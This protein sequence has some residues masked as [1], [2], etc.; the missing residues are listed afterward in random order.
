M[1]TLYVE[2]RCNPNHP[3]F[4]EDLETLQA[5]AHI[6]IYE[7]YRNEISVSP[8]FIISFSK[9]F[10]PST[11]EASD[12]VSQADDFLQCLSGFTSFN[13]QRAVKEIIYPENAP[14]IL[15]R[16]FAFLSDGNSWNAETAA[17][18]REGQRVHEPLFEDG[19]FGGVE[20]TR[21]SVDI[22]EV[23]AKIEECEK[24]RNIHE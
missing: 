11:P 20:I 7:F 17:E 1:L 12:A 2:V 6:T 4:E 22:D 3:N 10:Y 24:E 8:C 15:D 5:E 23:L 21:E 14:R 13:L 19:D 16:P 18:V 9:I